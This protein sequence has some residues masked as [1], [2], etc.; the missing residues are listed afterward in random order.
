MISSTSSQTAARFSQ[1]RCRDGLPHEPR[2]NMNAGETE[3][4]AGGRTTTSGQSVRSRLMGPF[5]QAGDP[6]IEWSWSW[7]SRMG[8]STQ[9]AG[10]GIAPAP[11]RSTKA[12]RFTAAVSRILKT[13]SERSTAPEQSSEVIAGPRK[14]SGRSGRPIAA[15][16]P[17]CCFSSS[18]QRNP[19]SGSE[20]TPR[21]L[22]HN[23]MAAQDSP[24][25][26]HR[27]RR[28]G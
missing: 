28:I 5:T 12:A 6:T 27:R 25:R 23:G 20:A 1:T 3:L 9:A 15:R 4:I 22:G 19:P 21:R 11:E 8:L 16:A 14:S 7:W 13:R 10:I 17:R 2:I 26:N 24:P 18:R